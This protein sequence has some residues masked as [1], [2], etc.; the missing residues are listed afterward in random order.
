[1]EKR[2]CRDMLEKVYMV[3]NSKGEMQVVLE[4]FETNNLFLMHDSLLRYKL[5]VHDFATLTKAIEPRYSLCCIKTH[6]D[7][8]IEH[9]HELM[10]Q[11]AIS[12]HN[13]YHIKCLL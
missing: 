4:F 1:M 12:I 2:L 6:R 11:V 13:D 8:V 3:W 10:Y 9:N 5:A 7:A